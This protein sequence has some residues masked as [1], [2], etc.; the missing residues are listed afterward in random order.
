MATKNDKKIMELEKAIKAKK[1][2]LSGATKFTPTT[3]CI[4]TL[5]WTGVSVN[6]NTLSKVALMYYLSQ[7]Q[8]LKD[9]RDKSM[10]GEEL[11]FGNWTV[12]TWI[13]DVTNKY[14]VLNRKTEEARLEKL[15]KALENLLSADTKVDRELE[16]IME[17]IK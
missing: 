17:S 3:N 12:E 9:Y 7:L 13:D 4:L 11:K 14:I 15:E 8:N 6:I 1:A 16:K 2:Q 10:P 5:E